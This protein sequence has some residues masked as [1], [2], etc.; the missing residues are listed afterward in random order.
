MVPVLVNTQVKVK[1]QVYNWGVVHEGCWDLHP[2]TFQ[3]AATPG[4]VNS[5]VV[6]IGKVQTTS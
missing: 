6:G 2:G 5:K 1:N 3:I 4:G